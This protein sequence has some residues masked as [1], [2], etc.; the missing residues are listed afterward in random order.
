MNDDFDPASLVGLSVEAR[1]RVT[2]NDLADFAATIGE[3]LRP[4]PPGFHWAMFGRF[5]RELRND[6]HPLVMAP[7]PPL[8]FPRRMWAGGE[9]T[10][11][12]PV[13]AGSDLLRTTTVERAAVKQGRIG[14]FM[15]ASLSHRLTVDGRPAID[16]RQDIAFLQPD[17][18]PGGTAGEAPGFAPDWQAEVMPD[19][20]TLFRYSALT[21]NGHRIHY[22]HPYATEVEGYGG[23]VVHGPLIATWAM[24]AAVR[25][26]EAPL[27]R[28]AYRG[29]RPSFAGRP[30]TLV[31]RRDGATLQLA[32]VS[33]D[34]F[35]L[36]R[37]TADV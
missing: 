24:Q 4:W 22:D 14:A 27:R 6:G 9:V 37:A 1:D 2:D 10:W 15:L 11:H 21:G 31:G 18:A 20:V 30:I 16:E 29:L 12:D 7:F 25:W 8:P 32:A 34:G 19:P 3:P 28:F 17:A 35:V 36:T 13:A 33:A 5:Q 23:T 26:G